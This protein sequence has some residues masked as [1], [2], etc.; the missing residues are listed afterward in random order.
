MTT[1]SNV[2]LRHTLL[3]CLGTLSILP[4]GACRSGKP[5]DPPSQVDLFPR[6][7]RP[8][9]PQAALG[10]G[11]Q[12]QAPMPTEARSDESQSPATLFQGTS[13]LENANLP[14]TASSDVALSSDA[15]E[16]PTALAM[17]TAGLPQETAGSLSAAAMDLLPTTPAPLQPTPAMQ[18]ATIPVLAQ[19]A[20][21]IATP[22]ATPTAERVGPVKESHAP[23]TNLRVRVTNIRP[24]KGSIKIAVFQSAAAFPNGMASLAAELTPSQPVLEH[25]FVAN[26]GSLAVGVYQD[27]DGNGQLTRNRLGIPVE[28]FG[29]SNNPPLQRG[30]PAFEAAKLELS[31]GQANSEILTQIDLP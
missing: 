24:G 27:V 10:Q 8:G 17:A 25:G 28:P 31:A 13:P 14:A 11:D 21:Q 16:T 1:M 7:R 18:S 5:L 29:F 6:L 22:A 9:P 15:L 23:A 20:T 26:P 19:T 4:L 3:G 2:W 12:A 30:P